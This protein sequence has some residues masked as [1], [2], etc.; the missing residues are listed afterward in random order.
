MAFGAWPP[1]RDNELFKV[2]F[3][4]EL[5]N[6]YRHVPKF[7]FKK[8]KHLNRKTVNRLAALGRTEVRTHMSIKLLFFT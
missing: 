6:F 2:S 1:E 5:T 8:G 4:K 3:P 7:L